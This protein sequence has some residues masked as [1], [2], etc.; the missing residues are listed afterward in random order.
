[1]KV[2]LRTDVEKVGRAGDL[3]EVKRG[4]ARNFLFPRQLAAEATVHNVRALE[5][6]K[7]VI[8]DRLR[9]ELKELEAFAQ[10]I[11]GVSVTIPVQ[12]GEEGK[13]FGSVTNR[14]IAE[15]LAREGI[16]LDKRKI[17]LEDPIKEEGL[18]TVPVSLHREVTAHLK[19][20]VVK[21]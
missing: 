15:A 21:S 18:F 10:K 17:Q 7:R 11:N 2:I 3:L 8:A 20:N 19:V 12:V 16:E 9:K 5:H 6:Q 13:L 4:F 1:V 14:D